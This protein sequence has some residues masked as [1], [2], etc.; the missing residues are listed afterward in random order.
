MAGVL[1]AVSE[2]GC[3]T[4]LSLESIVVR[5]LESSDVDNADTF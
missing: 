1:G 4:A 5:A 3:S 2:I